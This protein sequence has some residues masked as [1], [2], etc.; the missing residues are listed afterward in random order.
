MSFKEKT[1][2]MSIKCG[3]VF[4]HVAPDAAVSLSTRA[5]SAEYTE[6]VFTMAAEW[7]QKE[8]ILEVLEIIDK[9]HQAYPEN[10][11]IPLPKYG[12]PEAEAQDNDLV[13]RASAHMGRHMSEKLREQ[14]LGLIDNN[15]SDE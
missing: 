1:K 11:F 2:E 7:A 4:S 14:I 3:G 6:K 15:P 9:W 13:T 5:A 10:V 12:T 8:T